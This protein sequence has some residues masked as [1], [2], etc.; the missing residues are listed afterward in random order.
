MTVLVATDKFKGS[1]SAREVCEA[2]RDGIQSKYADVQVEMLPLADGGEGTL[3]LMMRHSPAEIIRKKVSGPLFDEI[4]AEYGLSQ[5]NKTAYIESAKACGLHLV[6]S[7]RRNPLQTTTIG[8]GQLIQDALDRGAEH[9]IIAIGGSATND[10]GLGIATALGYEFQDAGKRSLPPVGASLHLLYNIESKKSDPRLGSA[11]FVALC[12]VMN[13]LHGHLGAAYRFA[14]QKGAGRDDVKILDDGLVNFENVVQKCLHKNANKPGA[15]AGGGMGAGCNIFLNAEL[16]KG[17]DYIKTAMHLEDAIRKSD[18]VITGEGSVDRDSFSGKV[19]GEVVRHANKV[20]KPVVI[21]CGMTTL[22]S[23]ELTEHGAK[24][25]ITLADH[26]DDVA[27]AMKN[28]RSRILNKIGA[29]L[30]L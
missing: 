24:G 27:A 17:M 6:P 14:P 15:G 20:G 28:A 22:T 12:D 29:V 8:V 30:E 1:L 16:I 18:I 7:V 23:K 4:E 2:V 11:T 25:I 19:A 3:E 26:R 10:A 9:F 5:Q 21:L 13:P